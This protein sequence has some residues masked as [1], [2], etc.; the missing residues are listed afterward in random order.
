MGFGG[1]FAKTRMRSWRNSRSPQAS[2]AM[3]NDWFRELGLFE[4]EKLEN[5]VLPEIK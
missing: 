3:P 4:M 5:G 1:E 2:Y